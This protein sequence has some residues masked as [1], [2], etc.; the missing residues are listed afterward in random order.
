MVIIIFGVSGAGKTTVGELLAER[1]GWAFDDADD[2]H[3][4]QNIAKMRRG[5]PL[6][7][8]DR[9]GWLAALREMLAGR[10]ARGENGVLAC[11]ALKAVY[12]QQL[13]VNEEV[14]FVFLRGD[15]AL[16]ASRL[17]ARQGHYMPPS[18]LQS[19]FDALEEPDESGALAV[20]I[21]AAPEEIVERIAVNVLRPAFGRRHPITT[22]Y[23]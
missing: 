17:Q 3:P 18:L 20:D 7:E 10:L 9:A 12:R 5:E 4:P 11:S 6:N 2:F 22:A 16:I 23:H 8:A 1:L 19:Q 21:A 14:T 15:Y 13:A